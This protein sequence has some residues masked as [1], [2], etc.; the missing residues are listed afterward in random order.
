MVEEHLFAERG[1]LIEGL[2]AAVQER[3]EVALAARGSASLAVSGGKTPA[4][5]FAALAVRVL[6]WDRVV[7][8]LVDDRFV[9]PDSEDSNERLVRTVLLQDRAARARLV[10]LRGDAALADAAAAAACAALQSV[11]QPLDVVLLGMGDDGHTASLFPDAPELNAALAPHA[12]PV[13]VLHP[14]SAPHV[15]LSLSARILEEAR[16]R[17]LLIEGPA[18]RQTLARALSAG[19]D[20]EMPIRRFLNAENGL[21]HVYWSP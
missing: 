18:K 4:A 19:P 10:S 3:L 15:R 14:R 16:F 8:T 20:H 6:A 5:L 11:P 9:D 12:A 21:I 17:A 1:A 13:L 7:I 2:A